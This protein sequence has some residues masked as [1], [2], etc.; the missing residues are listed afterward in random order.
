MDEDELQELKKDVVQTGKG[1]DTFGRAAAEQHQ[2][3]AMSEQAQR[4]GLPTVDLSAIIAPIPESI[5]SI[6][7]SV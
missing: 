7:L 3:A 5:G 1:Y 4:P 6:P 2:R